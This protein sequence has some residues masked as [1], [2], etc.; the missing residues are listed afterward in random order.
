M[1]KAAWRARRIMPSRLPAS[2]RAVGPPALHEH[3][4]ALAEQDVAGGLEVLVGGGDGVGVDLEPAGQG[5]NARQALAGSE[6]AAEDLELELG[7]RAGPGREPLHACSARSPSP[8]RPDAGLWPGSA[9]AGEPAGSTIRIGARVPGPEAARG[10]RSRRRSGTD[11][12][13]GPTIR[14][15]GPRPGTAKSASRSSS[16]RSLT[17]RNW[18]AVTTVAATK[19]PTTRV[20]PARD[21]RP[22]PRRDSRRRSRRRPCP[23]APGR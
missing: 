6:L 2:G 15:C 22:P 20:R 3:P 9:C 13:R 8:L 16:R 14:G 19:K 5:A 1:R 17:R 23:S 18:S 4:R 7:R 11:P 10:R 21:P 12:S